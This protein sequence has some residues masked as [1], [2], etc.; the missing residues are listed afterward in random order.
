MVASM[1]LFF[2]GTPNEY[3]SLKLQYFSVSFLLPRAHRFVFPK[4]TKNDVELCS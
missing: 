3:E 1:Q 2:K 4:S